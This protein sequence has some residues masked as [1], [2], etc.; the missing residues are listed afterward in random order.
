MKALYEMTK[1]FTAEWAIRPFIEQNPKKTLELL[2]CELE[3]RK[4][5][6]EENWHYASLEKIFIENRI[7]RDIE[8][9]ETW[10]EI[11]ATIHKGLKPYTK[12]F[13]RAVTEEDVAK[14]T[15]IKIK[16][17][18]KFDAKKAEDYIAKLDGLID[19]C[20]EKLDTLTET[21]RCY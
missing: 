7:Y 18:S 15:E 6:L 3:I 14:L 21:D 19:D 11:I 10:E 1:R 8:E 5:E 9:C 20:Q 13:I 2:R 4:G 12:Q 17:I 16:R